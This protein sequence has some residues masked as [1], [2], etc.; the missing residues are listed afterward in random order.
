MKTLWRARGMGEGMAG[1]HREANCASSRILDEK[2]L[3]NNGKLGL[4]DPAA[5]PPKLPCP[6]CGS[7]RLYKDGLRYLKDGS[8][9]QRW[10]CRDCG[11]RFSQ[12]QVKVDVLSKTLKASNPGKDNLKMRLLNADFPFKEISDNPS[13]PFSEDVAS[14]DKSTI[15][16]TEKGLNTLSFYNSKCQVCAALT[17]GAKNL[18]EVEARQE[19]A[20]REGTLQ[21][22]DIKGKIVEFLWQLKKNGVKGI[23]LKSYSSILKKLANKTDLT[24]ENVKE[25]LA[26]TNEWSDSTKSLCVIIYGSFLKYIGLS[27]QPPQYKAAEELPL[28]PTE[29][30]IDQLI[31][32]SGKK[33]STFL[34]FLKETGVRCGEA[35]RVK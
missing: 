28:I 30:D 26:K 13:L 7:E 33:L 27:W 11:Y 19:K 23:T 25:Y 18:T 4:H 5:Q 6:E 34:Q 1:F 12:P 17:R 2:R 29:A 16:T 21:T 22:A 31:S 15:A 10:L 20:Q 35:S 8:T 24:P 9:V 32:G 14:H 3:P